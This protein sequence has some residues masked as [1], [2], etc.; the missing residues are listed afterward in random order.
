MRR[1]LLIALGTILVLMV[2]G[3]AFFWSIQQL[4]KESNQQLLGECNISWPPEQPVNTSHR[5]QFAVLLMSPGSTAR[6]CV[7][8]TSLTPSGVTFNQEAMAEVI[9]IATSNA[10][11]NVTAQP[12]PIIVPGD[13]ND[14]SPVPVSYGVY[15]IGLSSGS[16]GFYILQLPGFCPSIPMAVGY[17]SSQVNSTVFSRFLSGDY[18]CAWGAGQVVASYV[19][20]S[21]VDVAYPYA[22]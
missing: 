22:Y 14:V 18:G 15:T 11:V 9:P 3:L 12:E 2:A 19:S 1:S 8:Y 21:N 16:K 6:I 7:E 13:N 10:G 20:V 4:P 17:E 5:Q